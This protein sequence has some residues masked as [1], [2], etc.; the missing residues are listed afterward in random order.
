MKL[1]INLYGMKIKL[2]YGMIALLICIKLISEYNL[3]SITPTKD[4][5][6][7][8]KKIFPKKILK[9]EDIIYIQNYV[10]K[11]IKHEYLN[12]TTELSTITCIKLKKGLCYDRSLL[13]QKYFIYNGIKIR[14]IYL[15]KGNTR[16][17]FFNSSVDSHNIFE[18]LFENKWYLIRTNKMQNGLLETNDAL[19]KYFSEFYYVKY[20]N[21]RNGKFIAPIFLPDVYGF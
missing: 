2:L 1:N 10:V 18:I 11:E 20:L 7:C 15:F 17:A 19:T 21:N 13:L 5:I 14:P 4:E 6:N 8:F 12:D 16:M 3:K 9:K